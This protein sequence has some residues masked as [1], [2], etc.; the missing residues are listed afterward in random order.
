MGINLTL[1]LRDVSLLGWSLGIAHTQAV[2]DGDTELAD[3]LFRVAAVL[4]ASFEPAGDTFEQAQGLSSGCP[5]VASPNT[6]DDG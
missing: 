2:Q 5:V 4:K 1:E 3:D 6:T